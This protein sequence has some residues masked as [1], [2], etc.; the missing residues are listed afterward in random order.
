MTTCEK[1]QVEVGHG[2]SAVPAIVDHD[3]EAVFTQSLLLGD[4][5]YAGEEVAEEILF[6]RVG[7]ADPSD[8]LLRNKEQVH[9]GLGRDI[10]E[11]QALVVLVND[12]GRNLPVYDLLEDCFFSHWKSAS[13]RE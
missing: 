6:G 3:P 1:V 2:F 4:N 8:E 5:T 7:L 11:T 13:E 10:P 9:R 12:V